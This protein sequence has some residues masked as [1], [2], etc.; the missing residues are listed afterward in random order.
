MIQICMHY[1]VTDLSVTL[2]LTKRQKNG[3]VLS[4]IFPSRSQC[5]CIVHCLQM[6]DRPQKAQRLLARA[7]AYQGTLSS[8][9]ERLLRRRVSPP[10]QQAPRSVLLRRPK[11]AVTPRRSSNVSSEILSGLRRAARQSGVKL[12]DPQLRFLEQAVNEVIESE[13]DDGHGR[14]SQAK[15]QQKVSLK[16]RKAVA[17]TQG[18]VGG[19]SLSYLERESVTGS[20]Q[21]QYRALSSSL[22]MPRLLEVP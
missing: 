20:V 4:I 18:G 7:Q 13:S 17:S 21:V 10:R 8:R 16:R 2:F 3:L 1:I 22:L 6:A 12:S 5:L 11:L 14:S 9:S 19:T 15:R